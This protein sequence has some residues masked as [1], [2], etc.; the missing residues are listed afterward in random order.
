MSL[1]QP[2]TMMSLQVRL[3]GADSQ[4]DYDEISYQ[5]ER[6]R[7]LSVLNFFSRL[8][9]LL[10]RVRSNQSVSCSLPRVSECSLL[11]VFTRSC[12]PE[13]QIMRLIYLRLFVFSIKLFVKKEYFSEANHIVFGYLME[14]TLLWKLIGLVSLIHGRGAWNL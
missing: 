14:T 13:A 6:P 12:G 11:F 10:L 4:A 2:R 3:A 1:K 7:R 8:I 9:S 5:Y